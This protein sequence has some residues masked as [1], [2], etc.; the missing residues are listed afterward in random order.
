MQNQ[1]TAAYQTMAKR[2][3]DPRELESSLLSK[4]AL[5]LQYIRDDWDNKR[6]QLTE[7]LLFNR[8]I[9]T[10]FLTSVTDDKNPLPREIRQNVANLGLFV[11][12]QTLAVQ[13]DPSPQKLDS[14]ININRELARGLRQRPEAA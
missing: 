1:A 3:G 13:S 8:R 6:P 11:M 7:A 9:W 10:V 12:K 5:Q 4:A 2:T 14:L